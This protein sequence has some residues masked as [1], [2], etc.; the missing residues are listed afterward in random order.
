[1][2]LVEAVVVPVEG[3]GGC[4]ERFQFPLDRIAGTH[5]DRHCLREHVRLCIESQHRDHRAL[6]MMIERTV[7]HPSNEPLLLPR[8]VTLLCIRLMG[9][10]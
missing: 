3:T 9:G 6:W 5:T 4:G 2:E 1:V 10:G 7:P 8:V